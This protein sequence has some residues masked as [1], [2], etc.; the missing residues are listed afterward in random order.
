[1]SGDGVVVRKRTLSKDS[2]RRFAVRSTLASARLER[3]TVPSGYVRSARVQQLLAKR[4]AT[5]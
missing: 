1:M 3:R 5:S 4:Q 2:V